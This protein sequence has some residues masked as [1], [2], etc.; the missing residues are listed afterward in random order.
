[1]LLVLLFIFRKTVCVVER[2][3]V[4]DVVAVTVELIKKER[5]GRISRLWLWKVGKKQ[6]R[7]E[8]TRK[9]ER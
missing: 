1:M 9:K 2:V 8:K 7:Q 3:Y 5:C 4:V 6:K